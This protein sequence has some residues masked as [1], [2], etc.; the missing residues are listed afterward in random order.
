MVNRNRGL[1]YTLGVFFLALGLAG[2]PLQA[3]EDDEF[4][5]DEVVVRLESAAM[6]P[7]VAGEYDL[8]LPP[9]D[10]FGTRPIYRLKILDGTR[11]DDKAEELQDDRQDRVVYAEPNYT[12]QAPEGR[13]K[14]S[15]AIGGAVS[16]YSSQWAP[17]RIGLAAAHTRSLGAGV[18]VAVLDTGVDSSHPA[19]RDRLV[20]GYDF[21]DDDDNPREEGTYNPADAAN[22]AFGHGTHVAGSVA[23]VAPGASIMPIRVLQPDGS[24]NIWVLAESLHY[25][26]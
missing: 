9:L 22:V 24:G 8:S 23:L 21:V 3:D 15:W 25:A 19:L 13:Q 7:E 6:L 5:P 1:L 11:S 26:I 10:Q 12:A 4:V 20:P 16:D 2:A 18:T 17:A 14:A